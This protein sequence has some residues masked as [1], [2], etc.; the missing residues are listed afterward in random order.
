[1]LKRETMK[2]DSKGHTLYTPTEEDILRVI[3][4]WKR[5]ISATKLNDFLIPTANE[6][7]CQYV[8]WADLKDKLE[9]MWKA[10]TLEKI[11]EKGRVKG[12]RYFRYAL[13]WMVE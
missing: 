7:G 6:N 13:K 8:A 10:G 2:V 5:P 4:E 1:M 11:M 9:E 3:E 12:G